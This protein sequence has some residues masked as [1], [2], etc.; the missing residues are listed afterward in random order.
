MRHLS[1]CMVLS[2]KTLPYSSLCL[3]SLFRSRLDRF[4]LTLIT[5]DEEDRVRLADFVAEAQ[6]PAEDIRI[7]IKTETD[8]MAA[9]AFVD[10]PRILRFRQGHPCWLKITDPWLVSEPGQEV[11]ILDPDLF[12]PNPFRFEPAPETGILLM[13]QGPNCLFPPDAVQAGFDAGLRFADH[14]DI[15]VAQ[16]RR[17]ALDMD[18]LE[19]ILER[20]P[21]EEFE[22]FMHIEAIVWSALA[23]RLGGGYLDPTAWFCWERGYLKRLADAVGVPGKQLLRLEPIARTKCVHLSGRSKWWA[24]EAFECGIIGYSGQNFEA[25]TETKMY[26]EY[27]L[28]DFER[29]QRI[30][31][32]LRSLSFG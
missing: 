13:R 1:V 31:G 27:N 15:G 29:D 28:E 30:K 8:A 23:M 16:H 18:V 24:L 7:L 26:Q 2:S 14:V 3:R 21:F 12:F 4:R 25:D 11:V 9:E 19:E 10:R 20:Q 5:D 32:L 17:E 22:S 6:L